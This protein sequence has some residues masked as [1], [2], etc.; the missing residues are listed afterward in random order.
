MSHVRHF[1][2]EHRGLL[3]LNALLILALLVVTFAPAA[4][5]QQRASRPRGEYTMVPARALGFTE[6]SVWI[7]DASNQEMIVMR[8]DRSAKQLRFLGYRSL[9]VDAKAA[10]RRGR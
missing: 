2:S 9:E 6:A 8:Y 10:G 7:V 1:A 5:A 3:A 4:R